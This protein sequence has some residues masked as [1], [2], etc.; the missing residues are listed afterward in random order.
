MNARVY[1]VL[2]SKRTSRRDRAA[3]VIDLKRTSVVI[4]RERIFFLV[5]P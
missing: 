1:P 4:E 3:A 5:A 2:G